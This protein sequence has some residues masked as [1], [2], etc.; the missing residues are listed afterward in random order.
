MP[1]CPAAVTVAAVGAALTAIARRA[2]GAQPVSQ[3]LFPRVQQG[4]ESAAAA[5]GCGAPRLQI[6]TFATAG[7]ANHAG[8]PTYMAQLHL[9]VVAAWRQLAAL[10][11]Q[12]T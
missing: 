7:N 5:T 2:S 8:C 9:A 10:P 1:T 11:L 6:A 12:L 3:M 4:Y